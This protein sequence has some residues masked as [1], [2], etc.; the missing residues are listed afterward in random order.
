MTPRIWLALCIA[1]LSL[2]CDRA[3]REVPVAEKAALPEEPT[4]LATPDVARM[5]YD[6]ATR[7]LTLYDLD[8]GQ[9]W[10]LAAPW[11][12]RSEPVGN[13]VT[14]MS[15]VDVDKVTVFYTTAAG[16]TSP[17]VSLREILTQSISTTRR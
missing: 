15:E 14:F 4:K 6:P 9:K 1:A 7:V 12:K 5:S 16:Q 17:K 11:N 8:G 13:D 10:M 3:P 2:G